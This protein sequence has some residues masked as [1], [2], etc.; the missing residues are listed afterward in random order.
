VPANEHQRDIEFPVY[1]AI[2]QALTAYDQ[3]VNWDFGSDA[4]VQVGEPSSAREAYEKGLDN[5]LGLGFVLSADDPFV[6]AELYDAIDTERQMPKPWAYAMMRELDSYAEIDDSILRIFMTGRTENHQKDRIALYSS[7]IL[8]PVTGSVTGTHTQIQS[9]QVEIDVF[10]EKHLAPTVLD[11][12]NNLEQNGLLDKDTLGFLLDQ[13][14]ADEAWHEQPELF[15]FMAMCWGYPDLKLRILGKVQMWRKDRFES[16]MTCLNAEMPKK[17]RGDSKTSAELDNAPSKIDSDDGRHIIYCDPTDVT[18]TVDECLDVLMSEDCGLYQRDGEIVSVRGNP[19]DGQFHIVRTPA[20]HIQELATRKASW[21]IKNRLIEGQLTYK[22]GTCPEEIIQFLEARL[23]FPFRLLRS[24]TT[25]PT[26]RADGS[27]IET[28]GYDEKTGVFYAPIR[29][30]PKMP[31]FVSKDDAMA[32][33][34]ILKEPFVDFPFESPWHESSAISAILS[35]IARHLVKAVPLFPVTSNIPGAGKGKIVTIISLIATGTE[36]YRSSAPKEDDEMRKQLLVI[37]IDGDRVTCF[38]NVQSG[39][40]GYPTLDSALTEANIKDRVLGKSERAAVALQTVFFLTGNNVQYGSD[41]PRRVIPITLTSTIESPESRTGFKYPRVEVWVR[42]HQDKLLTAALNIMRAYILAG[43]PEP[44]TPPMAS[45]EEW[46]DLVRS[47]LVWLGCAD[48]YLG[49]VGVSVT[50][51][52]NGDNFEDL[53][54]LWAKVYPVTTK[55]GEP[56]D[57]G[58]EPGGHKL[59]DI[60]ANARAVAYSGVMQGDQYDMGQALLAYDPQAK[61]KIL[62]LSPLRIS[63]R[64]PVNG[65]YSRVIGGRRLRSKRDRDKVMRWWVEILDDGQPQHQTQ[66][67]VLPAP[68]PE[69]IHQGGRS[70]LSD[71]LPDLYDDDT[72][73]DN[74]P[75]V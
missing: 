56:E 21:M 12:A 73:A 43:K 57:T 59:K 11:L 44:I 17:A 42:D 62:D 9:C 25:V 35:V 39:V 38:D 49:R 71:I 61:G 53:L 5:G 60:V 20:R 31:E 58:K 24:I 3:W 55:N 26:I 13:L 50:A 52:T 32:S 36:G 2:P 22:P 68:K 29:E 70:G 65:G 69:A 19:D 66:D 54:N 64:L 8:V 18:K 33:L 47:A 27:V 74:N 75:P 40:F 63:R 14:F 15:P 72:P 34:K 10:A 7:G 16:F 30:Y 1:S 46:S 23:S 51:D 37:G 4:I 48:P 67:E 41:L 6:I 28:P 45:F